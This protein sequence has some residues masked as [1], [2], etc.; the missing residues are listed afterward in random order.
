MPSEGMGDFWDRRAREDAFYFVDSRSRYRATDR[1]RFWEGGRH[2]LDLL[3]ETL[4]I[5]IA[6][7]EAVLEIGCGVGRLTRAIAERA[8][9]V[10]ALDVSPEMVAL[11][12]RENPDL[13]NV[14]WLVGDGTTLS[15]AADGS[16]D[17]CLSHVVFQHV[18]D[19]SITLG[20]VAEMG[21]V[22][23]PGGWAGFQVSDDPSVHLPRSL[24]ER[25]RDALAGFAGRAPQGRGHPAWLGSAVEL[26]R[27]RDVAASVAMD[28]ERVT[29]AGT[30]YC[31][32]LLRRRSGG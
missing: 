3:L 5:A 12:R 15:G 7:H 13:D 18:P 31:A 26:D 32:I 27:L 4:Q 22:L 29:G 1:D 24:G 19:P 28:T 6:P 30:Q 9:A 23:R 14:E 16:I 10:M 8:G 11:A 21:R 17:A 2:D 25:V 20:Y